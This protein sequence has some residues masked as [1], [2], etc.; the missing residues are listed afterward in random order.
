MN[1]E[2]LSHSKVK[3]WIGSRLLVWG[4]YELFDYF[5]PDLLFTFVAIQKLKN[6]ELARRAYQGV[7][8]AMSTRPGEFSKDALKGRRGMEVMPLY[9]M[10]VDMI[11]QERSRMV[12]Q[13][14]GGSRESQFRV[15]G[16][17]QPREVQAHLTAV[18]D[19]PGK[20]VEITREENKCF[21]RNGRQM[22]YTATVEACVLCAGGAQGH[23]PKCFLGQ[24]RKCGMFGHMG[25]E[26]GQ[27]L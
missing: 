24:C 7:M 19:G 25:A 23:T 1:D 12:F 9:Q 3:T 2:D 10:V 15:A 21:S 18:V 4:E 6:S 14:S 5:T 22:P 16:K 26:C 17:G 13:H 11:D 8:D 20:C 27:Q